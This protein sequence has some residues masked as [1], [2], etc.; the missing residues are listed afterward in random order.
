MDFDEPLM[1]GLIPRTDDHADNIR[2]FHFP[3]GGIFHVLNA[4]EE[5]NK[6]VVYAC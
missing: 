1:L 3:A 5:E 4:W 2:W 6:C